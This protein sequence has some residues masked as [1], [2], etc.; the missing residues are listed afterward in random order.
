MVFL[1]LDS[2]FSRLYS[3]LRPLS[4]TCPLFA[5]TA[6]LIFLSPWVLCT[7]ALVSPCAASWRLRRP[8]SSSKFPYMRNPS[9]PPSDSVSLIKP[10]TPVLV[11]TQVAPQHAPERPPCTSPRALTLSRLTSHAP[12]TTL[13]IFS[14]H[15]TRRHHS[16]GARYL[17]TEMSLSLCLAPLVTRSSWIRCR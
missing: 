12:H 16:N 5:A 3:P 15:I 1:I 13:T 7:T 14:F 9:Y 10:G 17:D 11:C 6:R 4:C 2:S 8:P